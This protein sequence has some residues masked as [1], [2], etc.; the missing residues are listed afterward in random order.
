[1]ESDQSSSST[2]DDDDDDDVLPVHSGRMTRGGRVRGTGRGGAAGGGGGGGGGRSSQMIILPIEQQIR[3]L[4]LDAYTAVLRAFGA[5]S[6]AITWARERLMSDLRKD[7]RVTDE[8]HRELLNTVAADDVLR[9]INEWRQQSGGEEAAQAPNCGPP[10]LLSLENPASSPVAVSNSRNKRQKTTTVVHHHVTTHTSSIPPFLPPPLALVPPLSTKP[11]MNSSTTTSFTSGAA[12]P[13]KQQQ[14]KKKTRSKGGGGGGGGAAATAALSLAK[15]AAA[16][17]AAGVRPGHAV[18]PAHMSTKMGGLMM[19]PPPEIDP[20]VGRQ[21]RIRWPDDGSF[22]DALVSDY[23]NDRGLHAL[24]YSI[25][26]PQETYEWVDLKGMDEKDVKWVEE[27]PVISEVKKGGLLLPPPPARASSAAGRGRAAGGW[28]HNKRG[29]RRR[30]STTGAGRAKG[31]GG[32]RGR[33]PAAAASSYQEKLPAIPVTSSHRPPW[34]GG[35]MAA[36]ELVMMTDGLE[37]KSSSHFHGGEIL[38]PDMTAFFKEADALDQEEDLEKLET[39]KRK[40]KGHEETIRKALAEIG[41]SS[42]ETGSADDDGGGPP[43]FTPSPL[44]SLF[45]QKE[46]QSQLESYNQHID[47]DNEDDTTEDAGRGG[48]DGSEG[49]HGFEDGVEGYASVA[50]GDNAED[51]REGDDG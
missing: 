49:N 51:D 7:L 18:P 46:C 50:E 15:V 35:G 39:A 44:H 43:H 29:G 33:R 9:H 2:D 19:N 10:L 31:G 20:H 21:V 11:C 42:G 17:P 16:T 1:M 14:K 12:P 22:Y 27:V 24:V 38:I 28:R 6:E 26:T 8:Q 37:K 36:A 13:G 5:Q 34:R 40:A 47:T 25:N 4:E 3:K 48:D 45:Q 41:E 23:D 30:L 32:A